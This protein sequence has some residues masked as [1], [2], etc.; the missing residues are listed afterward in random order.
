MEYCSSIATFTGKTSV[1]FSRR[2]GRCDCGMTCSGASVVMLM[3]VMIAVLTVVSG[4]PRE[5]SWAKVTFRIMAP[6]LCSG[7]DAKFGSSMVRLVVPEAGQCIPAVTSTSL[8]KAVHVLC[9][10]RQLHFGVSVFGAC[11]YAWRMRFIFRVFYSA[12]TS[13]L[14]AFCSLAHPS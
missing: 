4:L 7:R 14:H 6:D 2:L 1:P 12:R 13:T 5:V 10:Q 11:C 9:C 8:S 3:L